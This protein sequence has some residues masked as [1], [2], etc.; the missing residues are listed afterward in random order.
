MAFAEFEVQDNALPAAVSELLDLEDPACGIG[1]FIRIFDESF[2]LETLR[3]E[4]ITLTV[5]SGSNGKTAGVTL[6]HHR[7]D[8]RP[9]PLEL[10]NPRHAMFRSH[11]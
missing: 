7:E 4:H 1:P 8:R 2:S 3:S 11:G 10:P 5:A 6:K 9:G